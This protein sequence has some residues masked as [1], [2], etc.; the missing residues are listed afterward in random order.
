MKNLYQ[1]ISASDRPFLIAEAGV[2]YYD[3]AVQ[4]RISLMEAAKKMVDEAKEAGCNAIKFQSYR[5][6]T[7]ASKHSPAYWDRTK[8]KTGS[9]FELFKKYD[10]FGTTEYEELAKYC[11]LKNIIFM[12]TPFDYE[13]ADYLSELT[14]LFKISS[15]DITNLPFIEHIARKSRPIFLST[16][17]SDID[18]IRRAIGAIE[19]NKNSEIAVLHCI[20]D[21]PTKLENAN[22]NM[23]ASLKDNFSNYLIGYS[24]HT[25]PDENMWILTAAFL[26]GAKVIEKHFTLDKSLQGND[27]YHSAD[28]GD[29]KKFLAN[30]DFLEKIGGD[31]I[32][33][34]CECEEKSRR[35]A[36]RSI[37]T[38]RKIRKGE[39][40]EAHDLIMK[41]PGLG[42]APFELDR[43]VGKNAAVDI[44]E[45]IAIDLKMLT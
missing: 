26:I 30:I 17:A 6:E 32:K 29:M 38:K 8:E 12:S 41:R 15:S 16:G 19:K 13:S 25:V 20:L 21:Y 37:H 4:I 3:I 18:E 33:Q 28:V 2:N 9:Q 5:A 24:D 42:L 40:I 31:K 22:L 7:L 14:P 11:E 39:K 36:R 45:D 23:I 35:Y 27:H 1:K 43:V 10:K 44:D 34:V